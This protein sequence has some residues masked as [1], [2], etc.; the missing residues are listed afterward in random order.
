MSHT[1]EASGERR[2]A[3]RVNSNLAL[4]Y[5]RISTFDAEVDPYDPRFGLPQ[6]F[7]LAEDL[8]RIDALHSAKLDGLRRSNPELDLLIDAFNQ[9]LDLLAEAIGGG[10]GLVVSPPL[11]HVNVSETGLSFHAAD[12][13][14]PGLHLHLAISNTARNYHIAAIGRVVF[15]EEEDLEGYRTGVAFINL[16]EEDRLTLARDIIRKVRENEVVEDFL[17]P[18][19]G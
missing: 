9:K 7:T 8:A 12:P 6:H 16:R 2:H 13:L 1:R 10:L 17:N 18:E 4:V 15:C 14:L 19:N 5:Q 3:T 11:Q